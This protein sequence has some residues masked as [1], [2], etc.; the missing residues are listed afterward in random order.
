MPCKHTKN[1]TFIYFFYF[2]IFKM[3]RKLRHISGT[4]CNLR[5]NKNFQHSLRHTLELYDANAIFTWIPKNA[6]ST[7]RYSVAIANG[8]INSEK[9][10][11]WIHDNSHTFNA[12]L[13]SLVTAKYTFVILRCPYSRLTST[14][15][16]KFVT[17]SPDAFRYYTHTNRT[18]NLLH[19]TFR[20]F[21]KS[22]NT[23]SILKNN[24]HWRPQVD[25]L[26]YENYDDYFSHE[27][28]DYIEDTLLKKINF[29]I[30]DARQLTKHSITSLIPVKAN[31]INADM[32]VIELMNM[33]NEGKIVPYLSL[34]DNAIFDTVSKLYSADIELYI[35][36]FGEDNLM[37]K[38]VY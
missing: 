7:M 3:S 9:D 1:F 30:K 27:N 5:H 20:K 19:L 22:L 34:Y 6:C 33:K 16:D 28:F 10:V 11:N 25:F 36:K 24:I 2:S 26:I 31:E 4:Q 29:Q 18:I 8:F 17:Q 14:F 15:L 38:N 23:P 13:N 21:V 35:S 12:N 37:Q 32:P